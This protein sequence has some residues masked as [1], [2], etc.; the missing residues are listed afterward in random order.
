MKKLELDTHLKELTK[1]YFS[2]PERRVVLKK[3]DLLM[4][5]KQFNNRL[6]LVLRGSLKG[7]VLSPEGDQIELFCATPGMFVGVY[8]FFSRTFQSSSDVV[9]DTEAEVAYIDA[10]QT[11]KTVNGVESMCEQFMPIVVIELVHRTQKAQSVAIDKQ[12][13]MSKLI[14]TEKLACLGEMAA[15]IAHELNNSI[16]VLIRN[17]EWV[18]NCISDYCTKHYPDLYAYYQTGLRQGRRLSTRRVRQRQ[19]QLKE[20]FNLDP[21]IS[22]KIAQVGLSDEE[23]KQWPCPIFETADRIFKAWD[24]G[25]ALRD[26]RLAGQHS[27]H[28]V[29]SVKT[30]GVEVSERKIGLDV[31]ES[32]RK[33]LSLMGSSLRT[34]MVQLQLAPLPP[35]T[36]NEG[37]LVQIWTNLIKNAVESMNSAS[38][39][40]PELVVTSVF[41]KKSIRVRVQD[42]GPGIYPDLLPRIFRPNVTTKTDG[43]YFGLGLGLTI[44]DRLVNSYRGAISVKSSPGKTIFTVSLPE[45]K[46]HEQA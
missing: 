42:N 1:I 8:S 31:N 27:K 21:D 40:K 19:K 5:H 7:F 25:A 46:N 32:I 17:T 3:K 4:R 18:S 20:R 23:V 39:L 36:A 2:N 14:Q 10:D 30:M 29:R 44:A 45:D 16:A 9:A 37:E 13:A 38:P 24:M 11:A 33:T 6:Y 12:R 26:M 28:V 22:N 35:I 43:L 41:E 15:G 34:I